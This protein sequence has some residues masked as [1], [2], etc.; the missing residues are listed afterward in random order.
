M[1]QGTD[2][3]LYGT[4]S[5]GGASSNCSDTDGCGTVCRSRSVE[6]QRTSAMVRAAVKILGTDLTGATSVTFNGT[7]ATFAVVS[8]SEI[9][10][11]VPA[12]ATTGK[13]CVRT[14]SGM[15]M[16][17]AVFRVCQPR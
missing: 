4:T 7:P 17:N 13:V 14:P 8:P 2:G 10:T 5:E 1:V 9:T 15:L 11:T 16:S 12:G 3:K 6:T